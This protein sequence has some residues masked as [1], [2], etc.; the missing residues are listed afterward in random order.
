MINAQAFIAAARERGFAWYGG[1]PCSFFTP[2]INAVIEA[3]DLSYVSAPNEG[4]AVAAAAGVALG[5]RRGVAMMQNSGLGNAVNPLT[6]LAWPFRLPLLLIVTWRGAPDVDDE[7][8]HRLMGAITPGLL[9]SM[10][11]P[12]EIFPTQAAQIGPALARA[13]N[14]MAET[15]RPYALLMRKGTVA[16]Y[17][18]T[19]TRRPPAP[20]VATAAPES[21]PSPEPTLRRAEVLSALIERTPPAD[22]VLI[23]TTG[24]TGREL[25]ALADRPNHLYMV[26]SMGC[27]SA[28]GLG[29]ATTR[30]DLRVVVVDGD[31][32]ALMR[33]GN[34]AVV[35]TY[36]ASNLV[37]L[38]LD[39]GIHE[40]TG[41]QDTLSA[42]V[43]FA[44]IAAACGYASV[45]AGQGT[46]VIDQAL[47]ARSHGPIF[48]H[49]RIC[50]GTPSDLPR[51]TLE[52]QAVKER[53]MAHMG[54]PA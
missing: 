32:A 19:G 8:Q 42:G 1:V 11:I 25:Y 51:P 17:P 16:P 5:G 9:E 54:D 38:L 4:D 21:G 47:H 33:L 50:P 23:A 37:H 46:D 29:L 14:H 24:Y 26:G 49:L 40:S 44:G 39:N 3:P 6:S 43:S 41:G 20:K 13:S 2:L 7:P 22:T 10:Q 53:L 15:G 12:W 48:A 45:F 34:F 28:L 52:P 27:A 31:G 36:G 30:P 35:A 18:L